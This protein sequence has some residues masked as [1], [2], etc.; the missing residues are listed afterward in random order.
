MIRKIT[1]TSSCISF[2]YDGLKVMP[3][4]DE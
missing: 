2:F 1:A 3:T 4:I